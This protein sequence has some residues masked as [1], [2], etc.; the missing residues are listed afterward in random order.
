M[1]EEERNDLGDVGGLIADALHVRDH[2]ERGGDLP[3]V[4]RDGLLLQK[5][6][7][8]ER[9]DAALLLVGLLLQFCDR[10]GLRHV[11]L[12]ERLRG[13]TDRAG[14]GR[15]HFGQLLIERCELLVKFA[16]HYPNLPVM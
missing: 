5:K 3:Q 2:L 1:A 4:A 14:A 16:S 12:L 11:L 10:R 15:A 9:F 6:L 13:Q 8:A 7:Q